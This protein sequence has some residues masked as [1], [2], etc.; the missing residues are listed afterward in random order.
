M[1]DSFFIADIFVSFL[2]AFYDSNSILVTDLQKIFNRYTSGRLLIDFPLAI[3]LGLIATASDPQTRS[4]LSLPKVGCLPKALH[5][6]IARRCKPLASERKKEIIS[7][8]RPATL[9]GKP[10]M[11][12]K[13]GPVL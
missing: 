9:V 3:P 5:A 7:R 2:R 6:W 12:L 11:P 4:W 8:P 1:T 10:R 13:H